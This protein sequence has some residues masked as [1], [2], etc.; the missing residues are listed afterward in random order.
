MWWRLRARRV[1]LSSVG[2]GLR[3]APVALSAFALLGAQ[4]GSGA[5]RGVSSQWRLGAP[6]AVRRRLGAG[7]AILVDDAGGPVCRRL[8]SG[9]RPASAGSPATASGARIGDSVPKHGCGSFWAPYRDRRRPGSTIRP[10]S[11]DPGRLTPHMQGPDDTDHTA[12]ARTPAVPRPLAR[13]TDDAASHTSF[14]PS[15]PPDHAAH[16]PRQAR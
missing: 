3:G 7:S 16:P 10:R 6:G 5:P 8:T 12:S 11:T 15:V 2:A 9:E 14:L 4:R 1:V 13:K